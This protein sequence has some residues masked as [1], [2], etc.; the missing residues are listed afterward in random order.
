MMLD[1]LALNSDPSVMAASTII[2]VVGLALFAL[3]SALSA[4]SRNA[5]PAPHTS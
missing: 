3:G 4:R 2:A 1:S 5:P